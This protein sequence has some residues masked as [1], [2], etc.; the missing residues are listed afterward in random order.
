MAFYR[1]PIE[2]AEWQRGPGRTWLA[3]SSSIYPIEA[4]VSTALT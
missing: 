1:L 3:F 2:H 4:V